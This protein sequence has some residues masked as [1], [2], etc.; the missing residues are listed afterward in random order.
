[1]QFHSAFERCVSRVIYKGEWGK[2]R[3]SIMQHNGW[4]RCSSEV[5]IS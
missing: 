3:T 5:M 2:D 4:T 1:M